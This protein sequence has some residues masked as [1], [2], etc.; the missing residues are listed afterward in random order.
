MNRIICVL[1]VLLFLGT[2]IVN[3]SPINYIFKGNATGSVDSTVFSNSQVTITVSADTENVF[4]DGDNIFYVISSSAVIDIA[5]IGPG[6]LTREMTVFNL[7]ADNYSFAGLQQDS[8]DVIIVDNP[9]FATYDL[10]SSLG[11]LSYGYLSYGLSDIPTTMGTVVFNSSGDFTF[12]ADTQVSGCIDT[13]NDGMDDC[14]DSCPDENSTGLDADGDGCIDSFNGLSDMLKTLF[15]E[16]LIDSSLE[17]SLAKKV[18]NAQEMADRNNICAA[19]NKLEN[20]LIGSLNA[21]KG[22][23]INPDTAALLIEYTNSLIRQLLYQLPS[24]VT[25]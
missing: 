4:F 10:K 5:G 19:V 21:Q 25:C 3:A 17:N 12:Q 20:A 16:G 8:M 14:V 18:M 24:D 6:R 1:G 13:D 2:N 22:K 23:K 15:T 9:E 11:P 7:Q